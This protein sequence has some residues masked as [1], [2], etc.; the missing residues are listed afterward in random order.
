MV[1]QLSEKYQQLVE[2]SSK[3]IEELKREKERLSKKIEE[4]IEAKTHEFH[5][6]LSIFEED[7]EMY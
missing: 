4:I 3:I 1:L 5:F 6:P 2:D 7:E